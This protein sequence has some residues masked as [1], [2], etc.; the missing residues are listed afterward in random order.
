[1]NVQLQLCPP[2]SRCPQQDDDGDGEAGR[3]ADRRFAR[4]AGT[5]GRPGRAGHELVAWVQGYA[6][7]AATASTNLSP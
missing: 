7:D 1:M 6:A 3:R 2:S 4:Q 5:A